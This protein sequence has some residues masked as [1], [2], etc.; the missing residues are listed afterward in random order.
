MDDN[1]SGTDKSM[2]KDE[3][4]KIKSDFANHENSIRLVGCCGAY[5]KTCQPFIE[6]FCRGCKVGY[7]EGE[8]DLNKA[9]GKM[10]ACCF[11][12]RNLETCADCPDYPKC[13]VIRDFYRKNGFKYKKYAQAVEFTRKMDIPAS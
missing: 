3:P 12:E 2:A 1:V 10:K 8:R 9:K 11:R 6:G 4:L 13:R 5:C 7:A